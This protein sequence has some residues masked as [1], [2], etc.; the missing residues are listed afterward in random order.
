M[1]R[2]R[3]DCPERIAAAVFTG[4]KLLPTTGANGA[5]TA[6]T[7]LLTTSTCRQEV[8]TEQ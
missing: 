8:I 4:R 1:G 2:S 6:D 3:A 5:G 7:A